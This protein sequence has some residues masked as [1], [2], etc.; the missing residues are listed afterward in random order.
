MSFGVM[1][2]AR[3]ASMRRMF[4]LDLRAAG[5]NRKALHSYSKVLS[6]FI[7]FTGDL[8][9]KELGPDHV[10]MYIADLSDRAER[11]LLAKHYAV[12]RTWIR[13]IYAQKSIDERR[14]FSIAPRLRDLFPLRGAL[15]FGVGDLLEK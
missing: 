6:S 7:N 12:V 1:R 2:D 4:L 9:V 3:L 8:T 14:A 11:S 13:W 10:R 15:C 5:L